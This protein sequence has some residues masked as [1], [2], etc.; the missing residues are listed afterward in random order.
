MEQTAEYTYLNVADF[1]AATG[2]SERRV[3]HLIRKGEI[4][5]LRPSKELGY[6]ILDTELTRVKD[7]HGR[8]IKRRA[9]VPL[10]RH[11]ALMARFGKLRERLAVSESNLAEVEEDLALEKKVREQIESELE[12]AQLEN[13]QLR[14]ELSDLRE[15]LQAIH[16]RPWWRRIWGE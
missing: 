5:A 4:V 8:A 7:T 12:Q 10:K 1:A 9:R 2:L 11:E 14:R 6:Q 15:E 16:S 3:L 13:E